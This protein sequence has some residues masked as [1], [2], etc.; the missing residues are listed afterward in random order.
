M[1]IAIVAIIIAIFATT[2]YLQWH[3]YAE[4]P[5][6]LGLTSDDIKFFQLTD[7]STAPAF[8]QYIKEHN[9]NIPP[10]VV[11]SYANDPLTLL[12]IVALKLWYLRPRP[13]RKYQQLKST[14]AYG[15]SYPSGHAYQAMYIATN[16]SRIAPEHA[17]G[18]M[19]L[20]RQC[21]KIRVSTGMHYDSD[22]HV[23]EFL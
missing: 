7:K 23:F 11:D 9:I 17:S 12:K 3:Y 22:V 10:A 18:F 21:G 19:K 20:A 2:R 6:I 13:A 1:I 14:T 16:L 8:K 4:K 15:P 5:H